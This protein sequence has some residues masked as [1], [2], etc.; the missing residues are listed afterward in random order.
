MIGKKHILLLLTT[1]L[2]PLAG[3]VKDPGPV[4]GPGLPMQLEASLAGDTKGGL[5]A[6][7]LTEFY[8]QL[9]CDDTFYSYFGKV[10]GSG[11]EWAATKQL[12]WKDKT[13]PVS[14]SAAVFG[15]Y[16]FTE[17]DFRDGVELAVP[18]DQ[19]TESALKGADLLTMSTKTLKYKDT[20]NGAL[21][22]ELSH[23]LSKVNFV[24]TLE[25]IYYALDISR[26]GNPVTQL[27]V[28]GVNRGFTFKPGTVTVKPDT[29]GNITAYAGQSGKRW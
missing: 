5:T 16:A 19:S 4:D 25:A 10:T 7:D 1:A 20:D 17:D 6:A 15:D 2:L 8:L 23:G 28:M 24:L 14:C 18:K 21:S 27:K 3:C 22:V 11:S 9:H 12:F 13:T 26:G 29:R